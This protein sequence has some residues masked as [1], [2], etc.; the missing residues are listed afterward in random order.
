MTIEEFNKLPVNK[1][2]EELLKCCGSNRWASIVMEAFPFKDADDLKLSSDKAWYIC[3]EDDWREAFSHHPKIGQKIADEKKFASTEKWAVKEQ[4]GIKTAS[5]E[6]LTDFHRL[7]EEYEKKF[8]FIFIVCA[9]GKTSEEML[10]ILKK[11]MPNELHNEIRI[12]ANE[13]NKITRLRIDK[14]IS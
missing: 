11:R 1:V 13:Q 3:G 12:A 8:G 5:T 9:T 4:S 14:M 6:T 7:N 2:K 10:A